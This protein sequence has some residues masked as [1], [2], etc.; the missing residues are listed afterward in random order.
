MSPRETYEECLRNIIDTIK[1]FEELDFVVHP[2]KSVLI[3]SREIEILGFVIIPFDENF[4][5]HVTTSVLR[6]LSSDLNHDENPKSLNK[7]IELSEIVS[8]CK[9][10][11]DGTAGGVDQTVYEHVKYGWSAEC[12]GRRSRFFC[13]LTR[14]NLY[15]QIMSIEDHNAHLVILNDSDQSLCVNVTHNL[16]CKVLGSVSDIFKRDIVL[17]NSEFIAKYKSSYSEEELRYAKDILFA[18]VKRRRGVTLPPLVERKHGEGALDKL[19]SDIYEIMAYGEV[20]ENPSQNPWFHLAARK[21]KTPKRQ[22]H[23]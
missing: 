19:T 8:V 11:T 21:Q 2:L 6:E 22:P 15:Y 10:L 12:R 7:Q 4:R 17:P 16:I 18:I 5:D 14:F 3:P 23:K 13:S 20:S 1:L 9:D